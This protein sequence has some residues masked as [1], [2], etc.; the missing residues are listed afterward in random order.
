M[1]HK[2]NLHDLVP[3]KAKDEFA[4]LFFSFTNSFRINL[5]FGVGVLTMVALFCS[6]DLASFNDVKNLLQVA[7]LLL[8]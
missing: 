1:G 8:Q 2:V 5:L 4:G 3:M 7:F 6:H